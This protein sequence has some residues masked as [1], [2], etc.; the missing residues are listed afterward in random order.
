[1]KIAT[2][3]DRLKELMKNRGLRQVD[4]LEKAHPFCEKYGVKL[5]KNDLSQYVNGKVEPGQEKLSILGLAL[6]VSEAWLMGY[7]AP[8]AKSPA[9]RD[10]S[11]APLT[12][13]DERDIEKRLESVLD[14]LERGQSDL[15]FSGEPLDDVTRE[16][17]VQSLRNSMEIGKTLAKQ[18]F[19][20][21]KYRKD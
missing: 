19:T 8:Q 4:I 6:E 10:V 17:L 5:G 13:K 2:T 7:D 9:A 11:S 1:M 3:A 20:P 21:K 12:E 18:K 16:L 14:D 15:A